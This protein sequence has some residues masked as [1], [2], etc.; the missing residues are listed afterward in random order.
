MNDG[1]LTKYWDI[2]RRSEHDRTSYT[3]V[4]DGLLEACS[5]KI[6]DQL[7]QEIFTQ[8]TGGR[9]TIAHCN[10]KL[11]PNDASL[12]RILQK[13]QMPCDF[14]MDTCTQEVVWQKQSQNPKSF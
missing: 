5:K 11:E 8:K 14:G 4:K 13:S 9:L 2:L 12:L 6:L 3:Q 7:Q 1:I 10:I